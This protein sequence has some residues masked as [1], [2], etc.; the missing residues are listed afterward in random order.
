MRHPAAFY[1]HLSNEEIRLNRAA[2]VSDWRQ[3][4]LN[5]SEWKQ[6]EERWVRMHD[7]AWCSGRQLALQMWVEGRASESAGRP[8]RPPPTPV[9]LNISTCPPSK[10]NQQT[11]LSLCYCGQLS[12]T[13]QNSLQ[14]LELSRVSS[15]PSTSLIASACLLLLLRC[16]RK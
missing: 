14:P 4:A 5:P 6:G 2:A 3:L 13:L 10:P 16:K 12:T 8:M 11:N 9:S 1:P 7:V 15:M